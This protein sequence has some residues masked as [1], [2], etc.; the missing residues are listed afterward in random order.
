MNS[1]WGC[2]VVAI[3]FFRD[4]VGACNCGR[5]VVVRQSQ[6]GGREG[7]PWPVVGGEKK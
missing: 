6:P 3:V 1:L 5:V 2:L 4:L 7:G